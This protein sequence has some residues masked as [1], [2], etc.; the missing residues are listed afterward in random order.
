VWRVLDSDAA[1]GHAKDEAFESG[2]GDKQITAAAQHEERYA[3][4]ARPGSGFINLL[5]AY[6]LD[7][8][9]RRATNAEGGEGRERLVLFKKHRLKATPRNEA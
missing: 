2:I 8:P 4:I 9:A 5:F 7:K 1:Q 3:A 6:G